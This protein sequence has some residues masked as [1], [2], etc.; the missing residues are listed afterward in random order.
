MVRITRAFAFAALVATAAEAHLV[1]DMKMSIRA[2]AFAAAGQQ[3]TYEVVADDLANDNALG[4][5]VTDTLPAGATFGSVTAPGWN[6]SQSKG[7]VT[8]SAEQLGPG[9]HVIT[10]KVTVPSQPGAISNKVHIASLGSFDPTAGNDDATNSV[11][12]YTPSRCTAAAPALL[13]PSGNAVIDQPARFSWSP[14]SDGAT[15]V[16]HATIE[17]AAAHEVLRTTTTSTG[18]PVDRGTAT[19]WVEA[20]FIDCPPVESEHRNFTMSRAPAFDVSAVKSGLS[21]PAGLAFGPGGELYVTDEADSVVRL[22]GQGEATTIAGAAGEHGSANGQFARFNRPTGIAV[23]PLD[24]FVYVADTANGEMR[25]LY[26]GGPFVPAFDLGGVA[27]SRPVAVAATFRGSLYVA[28]IDANAVRLMTPVTGTTGIFNITN[29]ASFSAPAGIAVDS[30][31]TLYVSEQGT[32]TIRKRAPNGDSSI[33]ASGF[34]RPSA[35]ALDPL[36]N[37]Y[38]CDRGT[39]LLQKVAPSGLVTT[40]AAFGDP[41]G[42]AVAADLSVYVADAGSHAVRRVQVVVSETQPPASTSRRRAAGH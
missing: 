4:L 28:D 10:I 38:V 14:S 33:L 37:L 31:G 12:V 17:G 35:L 2:P 26:T 25:V 41:A 15:Y 18:I 13:S 39:H 42:V 30:N 40:I 16:L 27:F 32:G 23:T 21:A 3:L 5:V 24:G 11:M 36:G 34:A 29:V 6:C 19:W 20:T 1:V 8:C 7:V 22:V 9:E